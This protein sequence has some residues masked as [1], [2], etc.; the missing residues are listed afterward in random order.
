M[1]FVLNSNNA[2]TFF[3]VLNIYNAF[4]RFLLT[5]VNQR[6]SV[7]EGGWFCEECTVAACLAHSLSPWFLAPWVGKFVLVWLG[8]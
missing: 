1:F 8:F 7:P 3:V 2:Y 6:D 4:H 5:L